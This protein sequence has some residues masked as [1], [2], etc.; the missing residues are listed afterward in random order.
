MRWTKL[1]DIWGP[2]TSLIQNCAWLCSMPYRSSAKPLPTNFDNDLVD[3]DIHH[4]VKLARFINSRK[5][6]SGLAFQAKDADR[7]NHLCDELYSK[8]YEGKTIAEVANMAVSDFN[9][10]LYFNSYDHQAAE[11]EID[12]DAQ[13]KQNYEFIARQLSL[14]PSDGGNQMQAQSAGNNAMGNNVTEEESNETS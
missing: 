13:Y 11:A 3:F 5:S 9:K 6:G 7:I 2:R 10:S 8:G 4:F 14:P 1:E 12:E